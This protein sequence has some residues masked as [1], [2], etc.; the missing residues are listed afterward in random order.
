LSI[1]TILFCHRQQFFFI[2]VTIIIGEGAGLWLNQD[3]TAFFVVILA[4]IF[5]R[6]CRDQTKTHGASIIEFEAVI[7]KVFAAFGVILI[8]VRPVQHYFFA[9]IG[10]GVG[11]AFVTALADKVAFVVVAGEEGEQMREH[12]VFMLGCACTIFS[13]FFPDLKHLGYGIGIDAVGT[14][15]SFFLVEFLLQTFHIGC[16]GCCQ[17]FCDLSL[18]AIFQIV[19]DLHRPAIENAIDAKIQFRAINLKYFF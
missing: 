18:E 10:N 14:V 7:G 6:V 11:V 4:V 15:L 9:G 1:R 2:F 12:R 5:G 13:Q 17:A 16:A 3:K 19:V 8:F